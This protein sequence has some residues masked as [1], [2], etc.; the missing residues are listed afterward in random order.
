MDYPE[1]KLLL[2][3]AKRIHSKHKNA[4]DK[5]DFRT[6]GAGWVLPYWKVLKDMP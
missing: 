6:R 2:N 4:N 1:A 3:N 5:N